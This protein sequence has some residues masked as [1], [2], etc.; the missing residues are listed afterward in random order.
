MNELFRLHITAVRT[1]SLSHTRESPRPLKNSRKCIRSVPMKASNKLNSG[2]NIFG[3]LVIQPFLD[4]W[5]YNITHGPTESLN[6]WRQAHFSMQQNFHIHAT[7]CECRKRTRLELRKTPIESYLLF[8]RNTLP[9]APQLVHIFVN[10][11]IRSQVCHPL[12]A[13]VALRFRHPYQRPQVV[14]KSCKLDQR[15][16]ESICCREH[17]ITQNV[18][19]LDRH[20]HGD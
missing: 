19:L 5:I 17:K 12:F 6:H 13:Q 20:N 4:P 14:C 1:I 16:D 8:P 3:E 18:S 11:S 2:G 15:Q 7:N 10:A 9:T